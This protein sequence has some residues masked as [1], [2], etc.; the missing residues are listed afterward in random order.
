[1][2]Q[3]QRL[4]EQRKG[5]AGPLFIICQQILIIPVRDLGELDGKPSTIPTV[6]R[7]TERACKWIGIFK[8]PPN[9]V[10]EE[11]VDSICPFRDKMTDLSEVPCRV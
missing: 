11:S 10:V 5:W 8:G 9:G 3:A 7:S 4:D 6:K 1:M 2:L